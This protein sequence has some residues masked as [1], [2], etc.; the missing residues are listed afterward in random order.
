M[1]KTSKTNN[2]AIDSKELV[3]AMDELEKENGIKK[4]VLLRSYRNSFSY[5]I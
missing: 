3:I 1:K 5:S 4:D 2:Q